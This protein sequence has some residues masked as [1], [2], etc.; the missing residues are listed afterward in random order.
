MPELLHFLRAS[1]VSVV[2]VARTAAQNIVCEANSITTIQ[3]DG[4]I[5]REYLLEI[6]RYSAEKRKNF[7]FN[8]CHMQAVAYPGWGSKLSG[9]H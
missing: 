4:C 9:Y 7:C 8:S 1:G 5:Q 3:I 2:S 6:A